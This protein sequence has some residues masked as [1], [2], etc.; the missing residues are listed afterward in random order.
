MRYNIVGR[1]DITAVEHWDQH[2]GIEAYKT[3]AISAFPNFF[4]LLGPNAASGHT[5][6]LFAVEVAVDLV[7]KLVRP[8][9]KGKASAVAVKDDYERAYATD[10]QGAL[11]QRVWA[12]CQY[13]SPCCVTPSG[14]DDDQSRRSFY[15]TSGKNHLLYPWSSYTMSVRLL[16]SPVVHM[17]T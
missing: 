1:N 6:V 8:I 15:N 14:A 5:S 9:I 10:V 16:P 11:A 12:G 4:M 3:T 2:G 13:V 17:L 7:I